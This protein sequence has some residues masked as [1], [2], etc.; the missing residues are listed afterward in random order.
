MKH[1]SPAATWHT[2]PHRASAGRRTAR[3]QPS[4]YPLEKFRDIEFPDGLPVYVQKGDD[5]IDNYIQGEG[6]AGGLSW[7]HWLLFLLGALLLI[8]LVLLAVKKVLH[9]GEKPTR[10]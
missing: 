10:N 1:G 3:S 9:K 2:N 5:I 6:Q 8:A 4:S 7:T